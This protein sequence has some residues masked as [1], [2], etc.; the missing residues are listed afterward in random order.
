MK[1]NITIKQLNTLSNKARHRLNA[2]VLGLSSDKV[3]DART[4][5]KYAHA[6]YTIT[7][8]RENYL[9]NIGEM[10]EFLGENDI[11]W[12]SDFMNNL[13]LEGMYAFEYEDLCDG[14]WEI[15]KGVLKR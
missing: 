2:W 9:L 14:L 1:Q 12:L 5:G 7:T 3:R 13:S 11:G 6:I 8:T 15:V 10:I 4:K